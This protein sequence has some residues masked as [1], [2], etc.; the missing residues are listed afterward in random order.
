MF[1]S[2]RAYLT[3]C[4]SGQRRTVTL[5]S[6]YYVAPATNPKWSRGRS[7]PAITVIENAPVISGLLDKR[8]SI[9]SE[10]A[11]LERQTRRHRS[12]VMQIDATILL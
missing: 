10:I 6:L 3:C 5:I 12:E 9:E 8:A 2:F 7:F 11:E 1:W 4:D